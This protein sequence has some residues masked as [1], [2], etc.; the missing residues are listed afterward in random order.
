M[1]KID[2]IFSELLNA[3]QVVKG[4]IKWHP[5]VNNVEK[6]SL[7]KPFPKGKEKRKRK[8]FQVTLTKF[9]IHLEILQNGRKLMI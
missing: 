2:F 1:N 7:S 9:L 3:L 6:T 5:S 4:I 8:K